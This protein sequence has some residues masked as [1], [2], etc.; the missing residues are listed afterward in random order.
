MDYDNL[1]NNYIFNKPRANG[2]TFV[3]SLYLEMLEERG[4]TDNT[5][6][7]VTDNQPLERGRVH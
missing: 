2:K 3:Y 5:P 4:E 7:Q 6:I 1:N